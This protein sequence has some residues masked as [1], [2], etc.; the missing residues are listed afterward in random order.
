MMQRCPPSGGS[1][2]RFSDAT[3]SSRAMLYLS[4]SPEGRDRLMELEAAGALNQ[5]SLRLIRYDEGGHG[6]QICAAVPELTV[7]AERAILQFDR[8][9]ETID[10][11]RGD[12]EFVA[13]REKYY[14]ELDACATR[15]SENRVIYR[16]AEQFACRDQVMFRWITRMRR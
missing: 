12:P 9:H 4:K 15:L 14:A 10:P 2:S 6:E 5:L 1:Y 16:T 7:C 3:V 13:C 8:G 11:C